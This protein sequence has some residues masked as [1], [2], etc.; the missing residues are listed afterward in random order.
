MGFFRWIA[1][2]FGKKQEPIRVT[3]VIKPEPAA[4]MAPAPVVV[5]APTAPVVPAETI[6]QPEVKTEAAPVPIAAEP[7]DPHPSMRMGDYDYVWK[8]GAYEIKLTPEQ[9]A[10]AKAEWAAAHPK[11][12]VVVGKSKLPNGAIYMG[13]NRYGLPTSSQK[14]VYDEA[15]SLWKS[16]ADPAKLQLILS[17]LVEP[18]VFDAAVYPD[19]YALV[20]YYLTNHSIPPYTGK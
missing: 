16:G 8:D 4:T 3:P 20:M 19:L 17:R 13:K 1:R 2:L 14:H 7:S 9:E 10:K 18:Y 11:I 6:V 15:M 5:T 12:P